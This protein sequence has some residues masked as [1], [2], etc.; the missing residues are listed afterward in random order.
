M[1]FH[2]ENN[3]HEKAGKLVAWRKKIIQLSMMAGWDVARSVA[4]ST[5]HKLEVETHDILI[6]NI[7]FLKKSYSL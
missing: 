2:L 6:S 5:Q 4:S 7:E 1:Q 3:E